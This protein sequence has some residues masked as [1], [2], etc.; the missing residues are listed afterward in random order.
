MTCVT[1]FGV[2]LAISASLSFAE[3]AV[4]PA[5]MTMTPVFPMMM[6]VFEPAPP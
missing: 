2:S 3:S 6:P 5:S 4:V 1:G